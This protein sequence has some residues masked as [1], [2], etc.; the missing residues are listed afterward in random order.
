MSERDDR[1][2]MEA[3]WDSLDAETKAIVI[4]MAHSWRSYKTITKFILFLFAAM[5]GVVAL[6]SG[7]ITIINYIQPDQHHK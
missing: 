3:T 5:A 1:E 4:D 7:L 6:L 2:E